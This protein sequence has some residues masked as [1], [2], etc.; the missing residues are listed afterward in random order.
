MVG[1]GADGDDLFDLV[2]ESIVVRDPEGRITG[3]NAG[4][5]WEDNVVVVDRN[6]ITARCPDDL[7]EFCLAIIDALSGTNA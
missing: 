1:T 4:A 5:L 2:Q 3:W 7:P 6:L